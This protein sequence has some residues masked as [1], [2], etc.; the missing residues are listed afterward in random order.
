MRNG[1]TASVIGRSLPMSEDAVASPTALGTARHV[2]SNARDLAGRIER[3]ADQLLG[4]VPVPPEGGNANKSAEG[5]LNELADDAMRTQRW[6][7]DANR[8]LN[9]IDGAL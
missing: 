7:D 5:A 3:L 6:I 4:P 8:A 2:L 1:E 9:R